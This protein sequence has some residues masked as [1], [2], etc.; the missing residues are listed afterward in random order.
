MALVEE[1]KT[2]QANAF[3]MYS[4]AHGYHWNVEGMLFKELHAFFLEIYDDV[5]DSIDPI[6]ENIRKL[7]SKAPFGVYQW[8]SNAT[9][10][11]NDNVN[12][13]PVDMLKELTLTNALMV[14]QLKR[15]FVVADQENEQA[16]AN[17]IADRLDKHQFWHWQL[18]STLKV[19]TV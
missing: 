11:I 3:A 13:S 18:T 4:Q 10:K 2:L 12:L 14:E 1:L 15:I 9:I 8:A 7:G 6:S 5:Y 17:F 16:I 19:T